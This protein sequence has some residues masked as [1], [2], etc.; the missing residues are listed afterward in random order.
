MRQ[1]EGFKMSQRY[2]L[3]QILWL[4]QILSVPTTLAGLLQGPAHVSPGGTPSVRPSR[5][6]SMALSPAPCPPGPCPSGSRAVSLRAVLLC[7]LSSRENS[8]NLRSPA[9]YRLRTETRCAKM[10]NPT[11]RSNVPHS[12]QRPSPGR[13]ALPS[14]SAAFPR[15]HPAGGSGRHRRRAAKDPA[16]AS[17]T[18]DPRV[19]QGLLLPP[20]LDPSSAVASS[21]A[22]VVLAGSARAEFQRK[23]GLKQEPART[24]EGE[25]EREEEGAQRPGEGG[26]GAGGRAAQNL[27][28]APG[29]GGGAG[30]WD[31]SP[32]PSSRAP[33]SSAAPRP[34]SRPRARTYPSAGPAPSPAPAAQRRPAFRLRPG[35]SPAL[36]AHG[37]LVASPFLPASRACGEVTHPPPGRGRTRIARGAPK[38]RAGEPEWAPRWL[39]CE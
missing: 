33:G 17:R 8:P 39:L 2:R 25:E 28:R 7:R 13:D 23:S 38:P 22:L 20:S 21:P 27:P 16:P 9:E 30:Q 36:A 6:D 35:T 32:E 11:E 15:E 14:A 5:L 1:C 12:S 26:I 19:P 4:H 31:P 10:A 34:L 37:A 24:W 3:N 18:T 29:G